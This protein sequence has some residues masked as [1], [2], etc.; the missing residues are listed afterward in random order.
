MS[1]PIRV[2]FVSPKA[3]PLF[4]SHADGVFGGGEVDVYYLATELAKDNSYAVSVVAA[5]YGQPSEETIEG[6]KIVRSLRFDCSVLRQ[7]RQLWR[8]L[9]RAAADIYFIETASPGV[10]MVA[11][12]CRWSKKP[13]VYRTANTGEC[14][15]T[16]PT[17]PILSRLFKASLRRATVVFTQNNDDALNL[18]RTL[19]VESIVTP[20]CHPLNPPVERNRDT[21]LWVG[22]S[23]TIKR[24]ET[25]LALAREFPD[26]SFTMIC[27]QATRDE[28]YHELL[29]DAAKLDNLELITRVDFHQIGRYFQRARMLVNTS[30]SE[31][32]ANTFV[33]AC[34]CATPILS[35][36]VNPDTF[37]DTYRC[38]LC[39]GGQWPRF[40][41]MTRELLVEET[42]KELGRNG[43][44]YAQQKHD[45]TKVIKQYKDVF[46]HLP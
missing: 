45:I 39:A 19:N 35:L 12:F 13:F 7:T 14:D 25:F 31:G 26:Q 33:Q 27:Q 42:A 6:V 43:R 32:F 38:G 24:P 3:Y 30:E 18:K 34:M 5:D 29:S 10:P 36:D 1:R 21:I 40:I 8:A 2:C 37:L 4:N 41:E 11:F 17:G 15:G 46:S 23:D 16:Y 9:R 20:N 44:Q 28:R 22:R